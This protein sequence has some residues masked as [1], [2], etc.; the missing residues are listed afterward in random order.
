MTRGMNRFIEHFNPGSAKPDPGAHNA[1]GEWRPA[2]PCSYAP[3]FVW[4]PRPLAV[5]KW[6]I[7]YPGFVWPRNLVLLAISAVSWF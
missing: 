4:P 3:L 1:K 2:Y 5:L 6:I 7:N